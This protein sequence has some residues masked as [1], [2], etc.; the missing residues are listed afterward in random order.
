MLKRWSPPHHVEYEDLTKM[1]PPERTDD[2]YIRTYMGWK[3][4]PLNPRV[5]DVN[6]EDIAHHLSI[7]NRW[8]GA[9]SQPISV[10]RHSLFVAKLLGDYPAETQLKGLLHDSSEAY[11]S[12]IARPIKKLI[13]NYKAYEQQLLDCI[14]T[15]FGL[16][17][18]MPKDV[19]WADNVMLVH[20]GVLFMQGRDGDD[21]HNSTLYDA[22]WRDYVWDSYENEGWSPQNDKW[23]FMREY[24]NLAGKVS[25]EEKAAAAP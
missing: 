3:F 1:T 19:H 2:N 11:L 10:A 12:D 7:V 17:T 9:T 21:F 15:A 6:I 4:W 8:T 13:P 14:F 20:E 18:G 22:D 16:S 24:L 5:E 23:D 25:G